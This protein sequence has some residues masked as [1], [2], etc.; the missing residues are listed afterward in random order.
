[1][2]T[3][4]VIC[5]IA[6]TFAEDALRD[7]L[8]SPKETLK[9]YKDFKSS[10]HLSFGASEDRM[11]FRLFRNNAESVADANEN[12]EGAVFGL[13][14]FSSMTGEEKQQYLGLNITGHQA[15]E[16]MLANSGFQAPAKKLWTNE[17]AVTAVV[18]QGSCGSCWT[19]GAVGGLETR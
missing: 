5:L 9:L 3:F 14:F 6:A 13:N 15:N 7:V 11:R 19:F 4:I 2:K 18:N 17:G 16:V 10:E 12:S 8:R 1:M